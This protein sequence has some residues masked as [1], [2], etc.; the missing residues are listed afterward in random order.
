MKDYKKHRGFTLAE[1]L[2]AVAVLSIAFLALLKISGLSTSQTAHLRNKTFAHWVA[3]NKI[4]EAQ[5]SRKWPD[6]GESKGRAAMGQHEWYWLQK[7]TQT[8]EKLL[9][10]IDV[11]VKMRKEDNTPLVSLVGFV[12]PPS[13]K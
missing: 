1:V 8:D 9:R 6:L 12:A 4:S 11:E 7:I 13:G 3:M 10:R 5:L 2:M